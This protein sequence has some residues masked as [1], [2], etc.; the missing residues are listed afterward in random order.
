MA[1]PEKY[2]NLKK[3]RGMTL[4]EIIIVLGII[5]IIAAGVVV[6]A[7]RAYDTKAVT[8]LSDNANT[9]RTAMKDAYGPTGRYPAVDAT[10]TLTITPTNYSVVPQ[11][12]AAVS[13]L[14]MLGK[15]SL[16]EAK[17]G[18]SGNYI[19]TGSA[20]IGTDAAP[21]DGTG[22]AYFVMLNGLNQAQCRNLLNQ[23]GNNW[24]F[25]QVVNDAPAGDYGAAGTGVIRLDVGLN[26]ATAGTGGAADTINAAV[27]IYKTTN[28]P[29]TFTPDNVIN[30]CS[31]NSSNGI[32]LGSR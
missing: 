15:L 4:L 13:K 26:G 25:V 19:L 24:D 14:M 30:A 3:Q 5:G 29:I 12:N 32:V 23:M 2:L 16:N 17:N 21:A 31:N 27:G 1:Q 22:A 10:N 9:V 20:Q 18:I 6:L 28:N 8:D 7:Q 11:S